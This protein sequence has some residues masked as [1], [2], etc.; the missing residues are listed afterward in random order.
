MRWNAS[1]MHAIANEMQMERQVRVVCIAKAKGYFVCEKVPFKVS[2]NL[3][4]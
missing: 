3:K 2:M 4:F 1:A